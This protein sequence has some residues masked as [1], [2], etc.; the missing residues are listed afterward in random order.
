M[1]EISPPPRRVIAIFIVLVAAVGWWLMVNAYRPS[2]AKECRKWYDEATTL[3][4]TLAVE[5]RVP[6]SNSSC[7]TLRTARGWFELS[8][9]PAL[10]LDHAITA[11]GGEA[12][13]DSLTAIEW[14]GSATVHLADTSLQLLGRWQIIPPDTSRVATWLADQDST[15]ARTMIVAAPRGWIVR[16]GSALPMPPELLVEERH[17]FYLYSLLRLVPLRDPEVTLTILPS[18]GE[19]RRGLLVR[20]PGRLDV[21]MYL[22]LDDRVERLVTRFAVPG[23]SVGETQE[24][25]LDGTTDIAGVHWFR[26][27]RITRAGAPYFDLTVLEGR[28]LRT[29]DQIGIPR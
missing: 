27:M 16:D 3:A 28:P 22:A 11:A 4:E 1:P 29:S 24:I 13:L 23:D 14:D 21:E 8:A 6:S 10:L 2:G 20:R 26:R 7:G 19:G 15:Q 12:A 17:Q 18:D 5:R 9:S 25:R